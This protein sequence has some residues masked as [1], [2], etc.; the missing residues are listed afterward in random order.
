[1]EVNHA[2]VAEEI[3]ANFEQVF[4]IV[5]FIIPTDPSHQVIVKAALSHCAGGA[6][7]VR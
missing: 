5:P 7:P 4:I 3:W 2:L 1:M 6:V